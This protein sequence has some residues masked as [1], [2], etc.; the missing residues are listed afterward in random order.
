MSHQLPNF[1][2]SEWQG[3]RLP[4]IFTPP[5]VTGPPGPCGCGCALTEDTSYG[6]EAIWFARH[7][8]KRPYLPWQEFLVIHAGELLPDGRPRFRYILVLVARQN[9]KTELLVLLVP[10]WLFYGFVG[11]VEEGE[12]FTVLGTANKLSYAKKNW[13]KVVSLV[14]KIPELSQEVPK[15]GILQGNNNIELF[16]DNKTSYTIA[17]SGRDAGRSLTLSRAII[18]ELREEHN[19][20]TYN[21]VT[22]AANAINQGQIWLLSN[23][24]D[25]KSIVLDSKRDSALHYI[26][27]GE[28]DYRLGLFEWSAP[29]GSD[30]TDPLA[31]RQANPNMG[32]HRH[33]FHPEN[34][35]GA[36]RTAKANG[37]EELNGFYTEAMCIRVRNLDPAIDEAKWIACGD[38]ARGVS[39]VTMEGLRGRVALVLELSEDEMHAS[40]VAAAKQDDGRIRVEVIK[41]WSGP[42]ATKNL[43]AELKS[44]IRRVKPRVFGWVPGGPAAAVGAELFAYG[45][46]DRLRRREI[47]RVRIVEVKSERPAVCMGLAE[48]VKSLEIAHS[49]DPMLLAQVGGSQKKWTGDTWVFERKDT[50]HCD[51][52]EA[53][54]GAVHLARTLPATA[55]GP[56]V[57]VPTRG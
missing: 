2:G 39:P 10:Y 46:D 49:D 29:V 34:I 40:L 50:G 18:D 6:F 55:P 27:T 57:V 54:G 24:G 21:A 11:V 51:G 53:A 9:G 47:G 1:D 20:D 45:D 22:N 3:S 35:L 17:A 30:P 26:N 25:D 5:L 4:R 12:Q 52:A 38:K 13:Q 36:A 23:Q 44:E 41:A 31:L 43:R 28:G 33:G 7:K 56:M 37:G 19:W 42:N 15:R 48:Q 32:T 8:L 14:E 16:T